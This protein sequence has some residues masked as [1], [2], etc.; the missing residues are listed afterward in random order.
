VIADAGMEPEGA[1]SGAGASELKRITARL[2]AVATELDADPSDERAAELIEE[3]SKLATQA[4]EALERAL[5]AAAETRE[6]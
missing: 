6:S 3:A 2:D 4:G 5:R 1:Q